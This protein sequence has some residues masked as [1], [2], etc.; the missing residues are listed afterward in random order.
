MHSVL[1]A[2][3]AEVAVEKIMGE[4]DSKG[5]GKDKHG[6]QAPQGQQFHHLYIK[7]YTDVR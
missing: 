1:P 5:K 3:M 7:T 6:Q 4:K 2:A